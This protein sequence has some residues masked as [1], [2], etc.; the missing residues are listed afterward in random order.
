MTPQAIFSK[1]YR[2]LRKQRFKRAVCPN[3]TRCVWRDPEGNRCA[4]G[5]L[6]PKKILDKDQRTDKT[7][8]GSAGRASMLVPGLSE[9]FALL[10]ALQNAHDDQ[11]A[12]E[13]MEE[14]LRAVAKRFGLKVPK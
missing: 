14:R 9:H 11:R 13:T 8:P 10:G 1:A 2:G 7:V 12:G 5:H 4:V 3:T 6:I